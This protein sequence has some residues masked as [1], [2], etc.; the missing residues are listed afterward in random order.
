MEFWNRVADDLAFSVRNSDRLFRSVHTVSLNTISV[1]RPLFVRF[2]L[3]FSFVHYDCLLITIIHLFEFLLTPYW[4]RVYVLNYFF[5]IHQ[6]SIV[7]H[8]I[9]SLFVFI[10]SFLVMEKGLRRYSK[11][12]I[13]SQYK[14][15]FR[16]DWIQFSVSSY[17]IRF[18]NQSASFVHTT[19]R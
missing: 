11:F 14:S 5:V 2:S 18:L 1:I 4:I 3:L 7:L 15:N 6:L 17:V 19:I 13:K 10:H 9:D 8:Y 16:F 12:L